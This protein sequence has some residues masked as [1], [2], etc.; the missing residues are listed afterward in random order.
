MIAENGWCEGAQRDVHR[1][2]RE[3]NKNTTMRP[4]IFYTLQIIIVALSS[5]L[6]CTIPIDSIN[7][8]K[9]DPFTILNQAIHWTKNYY[10]VLTK[11]WPFLHMFVRG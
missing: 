3:K 1:S 9:N 5:C 2:Q 10:V 11:T 6:S 4:L 7:A 8:V